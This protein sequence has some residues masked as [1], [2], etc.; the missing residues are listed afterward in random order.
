MDTGRAAGEQLLTQVGGNL[1]TDCPHSRRIVGHRVQPPGQVRGKRRPGQLRHPL[2]L[3]DVGHR[4]HTG[5]DRRL[6]AELADPINQPEI[7]IRAEEELGDG[8]VRAGGKLAY[9]VVRVG[10]EVGRAGVTVREGRNPD[11]EV[12]ERLDEAYQPLGMVQTLRM[13]D[14]LPLWIARRI[15][16]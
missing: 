11:A 4:H 5:D 12:T 15:T 9:Q 14:P 16:A 1:H 7:G 2:D 8:I 13:G 3:R 10:V 6:A